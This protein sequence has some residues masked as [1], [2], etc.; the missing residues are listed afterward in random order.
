M[1]KNRGLLYDGEEKSTC[2]G[3]YTVCVLVFWALVSRI[4]YQ[5]L[6]ILLTQPKTNFYI[7]NKNETMK[8]FVLILSLFVICISCSNDDEASIT[9]LIVGVWEDSGFLEIRDQRQALQYDFKIDGTLTISTLII[10]RS[11]GNILGYLYRAIGTYR[12][13]EDQLNINISEIYLHNNFNAPY[14]D[15]EDLE[16]SDQQYEQTITFSFDRLFTELL[17]LYPPCG[18]NELCVGSQTFRKVF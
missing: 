15:L 1:F 10:E 14:S 7:Y 2:L 6:K 3:T 18:P 4:Q 17:F 12:T 11:T 8:K 13:N 16:L 9:N 5:N